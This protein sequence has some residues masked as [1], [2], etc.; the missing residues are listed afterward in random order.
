MAAHGCRSNTDT[1]TLFAE[2]QS[3]GTEA[4]IRAIE[5]NSPDAV[6]VFHFIIQSASLGWDPSVGNHDVETAKVLDNLVY[7]LLDSLIPA[8]IDLVCLDPDTEVL[9]NGSSQLV[10]YR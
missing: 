8:H 1:M 3:R 4:V 10:C 9:G 6:P 2:Y 5:V 7:R